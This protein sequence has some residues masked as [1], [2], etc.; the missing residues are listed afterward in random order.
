MPVSCQISINA[1]S[2][3]QACEERWDAE[4]FKGTKNS[5]NCSG[6][7]KDVAKQLGIILTPGAR[8]DDLVGEFGKAPWVPIVAPESTMQCVLP[9]SIL[10]RNKAALGS[11][12][13]A[14]LKS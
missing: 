14:G 10:A 2:I 13:V 4:F 1:E 8:A 3:V 6:F 5:A 11:F 7:L 9:S 12:V